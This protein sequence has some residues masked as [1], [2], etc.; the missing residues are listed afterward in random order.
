MPCVT[1]FVQGP[2]NYLREQGLNFPSAVDATRPAVLDPAH[3]VFVNYEVY[4]FAD[5][6]LRQRFLSDPTQHTGLVTD[7]VSLRRFQPT[8]QSPRAVHVERLYFFESAETH[9]RFVVEPDTFALPI[10][11]MAPM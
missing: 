7:P 5:Q 2:E 9:R 6:S 10:Y 4:Y 8:G 3:R 1:A 11:R